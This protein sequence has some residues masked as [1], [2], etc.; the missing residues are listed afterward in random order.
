M[1]YHTSIIHSFIHSFNIHIFIHISASNV[2]TSPLNT[3][4]AYTGLFHGN[5]THRSWGRSARPTARPSE[6]CLQTH[7]TRERCCWRWRRW[8]WWQRW[9]PGQ[10]KRP[11]STP[12]T[13]SPSRTDSGPTHS[14]SLSVSPGPR[15]RS[16]PAAPHTSCPCPP[17]WLCARHCS[18]L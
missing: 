10:T 18:R 17:A 9:G 6:S 15:P 5:L 12:T 1:N 4:L 11:H 14:T 3:L 7:S 2:T 8:R 13:A 16:A